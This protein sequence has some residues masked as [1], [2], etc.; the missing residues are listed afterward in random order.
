MTLSGAISG[1]YLSRATWGPPTW[2]HEG[3]GRDGPGCF[4]SDRP[5]PPPT[6]PFAGGASRTRP[7]RIKG[8][9]RLVI[10]SCGAATFC[11][12]ARG[13]LLARPPRISDA[14]GRMRNARDRRTFWT[15][16]RLRWEGPARLR[17]F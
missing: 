2:N 6:G 5:P 10:T 12:A 17:G 11:S 8:A 13:N 3:R 15:A 14:T 1:C 7:S 16:S 4:T 9:T